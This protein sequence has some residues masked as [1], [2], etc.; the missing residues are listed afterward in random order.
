[1]SESII[2]AG[3][4]QVSPQISWVRKVRNIALLVVFTAF[5][6]VLSCAYIHSKQLNG[7]PIRSDGFGYYAYLPAVFIDHN[8]GLASALNNIPAGVSSYELGINPLKD[9][10]RYFDKYAV[11]T[12]VMQSP[13]FLAAH[14]FAGLFGQPQ[15][16]YSRFYQVANS[17]SAIAYLCIG[18]F[19]L[20]RALRA[21]HS[22]VI[23]LATVALTVFATN[24][25][26]YA[27][28]D[29]SFSHI[30]Q[31]ALTSI[32]IYLLIGGQSI[33][34]QLPW[35]WTVSVGLI[36][37][38]I[39]LTRLTN[40]PI[41]LL[42]AVFFLG[43][44]RESGDIKSFF[45]DASLAACCALLI[46]FPQLM[47]WKHMTGHWFVNAYAMVGEDAKFYWSHPALVDYLFSIRKGALFWSPLL[48]LALVGFPSLTRRQPML[49]WTAAIVLMLH[50][51]ICS[52]WYYWSFG[53]SFGSRPMVDVMPLFAL[54][55]AMTV[56]RLAKR[57]TVPM[58]ACAAAALILLNLTLM[59]SYWYRFIPF[60]QT[61]IATLLRL[62][63][64]LWA[65]Q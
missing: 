61:D 49:G 51:Y 35:K 55:L 59:Y 62:P 56:D 29:A 27:T 15:T 24:V 64:R 31:F 13:F 36:T 44:L 9:T 20:Y 4:I 60:D 41:A 28:Y 54:P 47:Y 45:F 33:N 53:G 12:A 22:S 34:G 8:L 3:L 58:L 25:F 16:G 40:A 2:E 46:L 52:S 17:L 37:G 21:N 5:A 48:I 30:Y 63:G 65:G 7:P 14:V 42:P 32:L 50:I 11:G 57:Y 39:T 18:M 6:A 23:A 19:F 26:H 43:R 1:V 38:L 10:G